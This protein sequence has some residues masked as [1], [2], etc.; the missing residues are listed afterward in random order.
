MV[1]VH[2]HLKLTTTHMLANG[3][4]D[5]ITGLESWQSITQFTKVHGILVKSTVILQYIIQTATLTKD[6]LKII[7]KVAMGLIPGKMVIKNLH[8]IRTI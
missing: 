1:I 4:K 8:I 3:V 7:R 5:Y 2:S 6:N